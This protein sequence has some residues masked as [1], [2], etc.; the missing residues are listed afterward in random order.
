L[1]AQHNLPDENPANDQASTNVT[2][3]PQ[4]T[5]MHVGNLTAI[6]S[7]DGSSWSAT[8]E[9]AVH[10]AAHNL[11]NGVTVVGDWTPNS[12]LV[13]NTCTTGDLGGFGTCIVLY[14]S[15]SNKR[16][17]VTFAV[18]SLTKAGYTYAS[19]SNHD[20]DGGSDGTTIKVTKP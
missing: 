18:N 8:V 9:I 5:G 16:K 6:P 12:F 10:D 2:V 19:G 14:P 11:I 13:A 3:N 1:T 15:I 7:N 20:V 17:F 4:S